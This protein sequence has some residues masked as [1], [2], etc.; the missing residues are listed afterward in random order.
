MSCECEIE[1]QTTSVM[2]IA[3][4]FIVLSNNE[5]I[6]V[7]RLKVLK[8]LFFAQCI[9][10]YF[11][12]TPLFFEAFEA[13]DNGPVVATV[14]STWKNDKKNMFDTSKR[15]IGCYEKFITR[16]TFDLTKNFLGEELSEITH[17]E[18]SAWNQVFEKGCNNIIDCDKIKNFFPMHKVILE[19]ANAYFENNSG[20]D[21]SLVLPG[22]KDLSFLND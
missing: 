7:H 20:Y 2:D 6:G 12:D 3:Q 17:S 16:M 11:F 19:K 8:Q 14:Y 13:W 22:I 1:S 21:E 4:E 15:K 18:N 9:S 5:N 10:L